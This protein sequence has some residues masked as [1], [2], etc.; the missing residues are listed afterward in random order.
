[1]GGFE[2]PNNGDER[3]FEVIEVSIGAELYKTD[4]EFNEFLM[5]EAHGDPMAFNELRKMPAEIFLTLLQQARKKN[6]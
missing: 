1:M 4:K 2:I 6:G 5:Q 3:T